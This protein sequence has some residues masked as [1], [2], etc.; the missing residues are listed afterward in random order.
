MKNQ[1]GLT[2]I[3]LLVSLLV[4]FLVLFA[5]YESYISLLQSRKQQLKISQS[6]MQLD[7]ALE[8]LRKDIELAGFG[9]YR[10][11]VSNLSYQEAVSESVC[12]P[13]QYNVTN[14]PPKP[15]DLGSLACNNSDY[16]V[17]RGSALN[18]DKSSAR[19]W[20]LFLPSSN[21][22]SKILYLGETSF[23]TSDHCIVLDI[24]KALF[25]QLNQWDFSCLTFSPLDTTKM[26][27]LYGV[28][29]S[30]LRM[31]FNRVDYFLKKPENNFPKYCHPST[32]ILY[33]GEISHSNGKRYEQP[34]LDCVFYFRI[35]ID[36]DTNDDGTIDNHTVTLSSYD[37]NSIYT[38]VKSINI[39]LVY[40]EGRKSR[41]IVSSNSTVINLCDGT[42]VDLQLPSQYYRWRIIQRKFYPFNL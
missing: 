9:L 23:E 20:G 30:I 17:L 28:N 10:Q 6:N 12:S 4:G 13:N 33:R 15:I 37:A 36:L 22:S 5:L 11:V 35:C 41:N 3:E 24:S 29:D 32:Y 39:Y 1:K 42:N 38:Q 21:S 7:I 2:L 8:I 40:Q 31:P 16:L 19:R 26:Y 14:E 34:L 25:V 27:L 18:I